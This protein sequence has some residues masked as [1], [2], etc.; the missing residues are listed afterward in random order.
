MII[1]DDLLFTF[2]QT[3]IKKMSN[4]EKE[5]KIIS[6]NKNNY[7]KVSEQIKSC[8]NSEEKQPREDLKKDA[9][10][11]IPVSKWNEF[12]PYPT[13]KSLRQIIFR[14][15]QNGFGKVLRKIDGRLYICVK[16][17]DEWVE[18]TKL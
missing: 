7:S 13:V 3:I 15:E 2:M 17:F 6:S 4:I 14:K 9:M 5:L 16:D 12:Y 1:D 18:T 11:L 10:G 8:K